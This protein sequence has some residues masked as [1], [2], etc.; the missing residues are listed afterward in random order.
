MASLRDLYANHPRAQIRQL[1]K[2]HHIGL[3]LARYH[4]VK[5]RIQAA[6]L[7]ILDTATVSDI[8]H[9]VM[10]SDCE[11]QA[12]DA[13]HAMLKFMRADINILNKIKE[14]SHDILA[15]TDG[16]PDG[17]FSADQAQ[18]AL[19]DVQK[20]HRAMIVFLRSLQRYSI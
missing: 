10:M 12:L 18:I 1:K 17:R 19:E 20:E 6:Q 13:Y 4:R 14:L 5:A 16:A 8:S 9:L 2:S 3:R 15:L 11:K 7:V